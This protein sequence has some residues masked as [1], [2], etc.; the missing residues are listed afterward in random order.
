[1]SEGI[2][3]C[4]A[5]A[6]YDMVT[7]LAT[8]ALTEID[9]WRADHPGP[10]PSSTDS[11]NAMV[12]WRALPERYSAT[13]LP[14]MHG[15]FSSGGGEAKQAEKAV[16]YAKHHGAKAVVLSRDLDGDEH[17]AHAYDVFRT[18]PFANNAPRVALALAAPCRES[19]ILA[20]FEPE[21][22]SESRTLRDL[23][24]ELAFDPTRYPERTRPTTSPKAAKDILRRLTNGD[25]E[26]EHRCIAE[27]PLERLQERGEH[28]GL[29]DYLDNG[30][31]RLRTLSPLIADSAG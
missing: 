10:F 9:S 13:G 6:D 12:L 27:S 30:V 15:K 25:Y 2:V 20:G 16:R 22:D 19:W 8:R 18:E 24:T 21:T 3:F 17:R 1:M 11:G 28:N 14:P 5:R 23:T 7:M 31:P 29:R 26:R 4:E